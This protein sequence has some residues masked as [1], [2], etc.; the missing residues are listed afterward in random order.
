MGL[1]EEGVYVNPVI[2]PAVA[3]GT[4]RLRTS[5]MAT[6]TR[7]HLDWILNGFEVV[8]KRTGLI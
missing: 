8:G 2:A 3:P 4:Q 7:E 1:Y 5:D 6:H